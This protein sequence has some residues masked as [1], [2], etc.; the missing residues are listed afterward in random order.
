MHC[1]LHVG[2]EL[3]PELRPERDRCLRAGVVPVSVCCFLSSIPHAQPG[4]ENE[5]REGSLSR[6][7]RF[8][9][10][11][12][13]SFLSCEKVSWRTRTSHRV[14]LG[15]GGR[16]GGLETAGVVL[17]LTVGGEGEDGY[18]VKCEAHQID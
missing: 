11:L 7:P 2:N 16:W 10:C 4:S 9:V 8:V 3:R 12:W 1:S 17:L 18:A 13:F 14:P 15:E 6:V 5:P